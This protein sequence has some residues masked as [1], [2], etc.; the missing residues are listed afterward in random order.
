MGVHTVKNDA[1]KGYGEEENLYKK[2][3]SY[4]A[5]RLWR[6]ERCVWLL[7]FALGILLLNIFP[8]K[9]KFDIDRCA[10]ELLKYQEISLE[11]VK[12]RKKGHTS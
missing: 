4:L 3:V 1:M 6:R 5:R 9:V 11:L 2:Q 10:H 8:E 12:N 7:L